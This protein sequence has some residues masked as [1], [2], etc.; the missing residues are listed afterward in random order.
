MTRDRRDSGRQPKQ[1]GKPPR[2]LVLGALA[3]TATSAAGSPGLQPLPVG[4]RRTVGQ[5]AT[6]RCRCRRLAG[7]TARCSRHLVGGWLADTTPCAELRRAARRRTR[8]LRHP[9]RSAERRA[10]RFHR[11][12]G[13]EVEVRTEADPAL[14]L[15]RRA[16]GSSRAEQA[17]RELLA[18]TGVDLPLHRR[19][20][21]S[22]S[23]CRGCRRRIDVTARRSPRFLAQ[24][25]RA[26]ARHAADHHGRPAERDRAA[27][28]DHAARRA[29]QRHRH[30][31]PG[32]RGRRRPAG[33]QPVDPRLRRPHRHL[34]RR[35]ARLRRLLARPLQHRAGRGR[36]GPGLALRRPRLDRRLGQPGHQGAA[37][38][39]R[40]ATRRSPA[41]PTTS[42][43]PRSTSTSRSQRRS[44]ARRVRLNAHVDAAPTPRAATRSA[45]ERWG[46]APSLA[47]GLGTP[48]RVTLSY[49]HLDQDNVPDYGIPWVP[50]T[51]VPLAAYADQPAPVDFDNFYGLTDRDYEKT[52]TDLATAEVEHDF[53]ERGHP[54]Q[55]GAL[56]PHD[57]ATR[58][59]PRRASP[60]TTAPT[61]TASCSRATWTDTIL[62]HQNDLTVAL[63]HRRRRARPGHRRR[64]RPRDLG[65]LRPHRP[66]GA[67]RRPLPSR[68]GRSLRRARSPAPARAPRARPTPRR[69]TPS[70]PSS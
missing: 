28:R 33:R 60:A 13:V 58:S 9:S 47:F 26:A 61:S 16:R 17:L 27:G 19:R 31:H 66:G 69:S 37:A 22:S 8:S 20:R 55:P 21:R 23:S 14:E 29:A 49:S 30:Q 45:N 54:A 48:T 18:G 39:R 50:P 63:R 42:G 36:Q 3:A 7:D 34:R 10:R 62:A 15:A 67:A 52:I 40:R 57:A 2:W 35:R 68:P 43:A 32:R 1:S 41:A 51:N 70:T 56:R 64:G 6:R 38:R 12:D 5:L 11:G 65:E 59:S 4:E 46:V 44:R 25:H 53:N 24:V